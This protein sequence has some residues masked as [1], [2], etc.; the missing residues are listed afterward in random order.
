MKR[1]LRID[2]QPENKVGL[3]KLRVGVLGMGF[4]GGTHTQ[5]WQRGK[6]VFNWPIDVELTALFDIPAQ[7]ITPEA[8]LYEDLDLDSIDAVDLV[9]RL[10]EITKKR[11]QPDRFKG[12]RTVKDVVDAVE[13]LIFAR[14]GLNS[15]S[16]TFFAYASLRIRL[17]FSLI[18]SF[19]PMLEGP[20]PPRA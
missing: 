16:N 8:R 19:V 17:F 7:K 15:P 13:E 4:M 3:K 10:Q 14:S 9:V 1:D 6:A 20:R 11:I 18:H 2:G 5:A 12:V